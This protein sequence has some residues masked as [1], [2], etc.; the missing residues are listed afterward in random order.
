MTSTSCSS[1]LL[2]T[3]RQHVPIA[4]SG[5]HSHR[6]RRRRACVRKRHA[7][8]DDADAAR[9]AVGELRRNTP[10]VFGHE[11][12]HAGEVLGNTQTETPRVVARRR[13]LVAQHGPRAHVHEA[14]RTHLEHLGERQLKR[15]RHVPERQRRRS[16]LVDE[17]EHALAPLHQSS[18]DPAA[19]IRGSRCLRCAAQELLA[20]HRL[21]D[22]N[23]DWLALGPVTEQVHERTLRASDVE[24]LRHHQRG[25]RRP[26]PNGGPQSPIA[27]EQRQSRGT[28]SGSAGS[29]RRSRLRARGTP[30]GSPAP[31]ASTSAESSTSMSVG[32]SASAL[33]PRR[34]RL[35]GTRGQS[36]LASQY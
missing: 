16:H 17:L 22:R 5:A 25:R 19:R 4:S 6:K 7:I 10:D 31:Y 2:G 8:G 34:R 36:P 35:R 30:R 21:K 23:C 12:V 24:V 27:A 32:A 13:Q 26:R 9:R 11:A 18:A 28:R 29:G 20:I 1:R 14:D 33:P 3:M 15:G